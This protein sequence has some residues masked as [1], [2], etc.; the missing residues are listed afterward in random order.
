M[1]KYLIL[2][3]LASI[4]SAKE[5]YKQ[6]RIYYQN[7]DQL[8]QLLQ[9]GIDIDHSHGEKNEWIEFAI[10]ESKLSTLNSNFFDYEIIHQNLEEFYLSRLEHD[11]ESRDFELGSMGGYYTFD[12]IEEQLDKLHEN[13]PNLITEKLSLG[14]TLEGRDVWMVKISDNPNVDED[15]PEML[16]TGLHHAREPMSY[17]NLFYF[18]NW[19]T[20]NYGIDPEATAL[21][22]NRELYFLPAINPDGLVYNQQIAPNGGGMQRKNMKESCLSSPDGIDLNRNYS[23]MWGYDDSGSSSDGCSETYRGAMPFSELETQ[24]VKE[25]VESHDFPIALNYHS[26]SNLLIYPY[27]YDPSIPVPQ[28][29]LDIFLEYGEIMTQYNNYLLG[30]GIE[31]VGYTVNGEACDWMYG[32]HGIFAYTPEIGNFDDGFWPATN[33]I[34]P[35]A[36]ENLFPNKFVAWNVGASYDIDF[37]IDEGPYVPGNT[38]GT[39]LSIFN[40]GLGDSNGSLILS[41]SSSD[42]NVLFET[43]SVEIGALESRMSIDLGDILTFQISPTAPNGV[44]AEFMI[45]ILDDDGYD[46]ST[47]VEIIIGESES[48]VSYDFEQSNGWLV[49]SADDDATAGIWEL[50]IPVATFFDGNQAQAGEDYSEEGEKCFLT[51][52]STSPGSVGFDDVDGGKTTLFSPVFNLVDYDEA[53]VSYSRWYTNDV[54]DNPGTDY[55]TVDVTANG[56]ETWSNLENSNESQDQWIK[57]TYLLSNFIE[58]SDDIQFRFVAE[59]VNNPGDSGTGG[60]IVEAAIDDFSI[61]IFNQETQLQGDING[62]GG[63]NVLDVVALVNFILSA[64]CPDS[65][66]VNSDGGCNVLDVVT[67]VNLILE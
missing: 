57:K 9:L 16:Y 37:S 63:L 61:S 17:M 2:F 46:H 49:G 39:N 52:A 48:L 45:H 51:G 38:Y 59:D 1:K 10:A 20:E 65:S 5:V 22:D 4:L 23:F 44:M 26:Y 13:F 55:W 34:I 14:Q 19:L 32:E 43:E 28:N 21:V 62:D 3:L 60:S 58:F 11:F 27:G 64:N 54:G 50:A 33:R 7:Q 42:G 18:M 53:L 56:G 29:D 25:F 67:L 47:M 36:E 66:D 24:I 35:L 40:Q 12:E 8:F 6:I 41:I 30:T 15:E 31:T